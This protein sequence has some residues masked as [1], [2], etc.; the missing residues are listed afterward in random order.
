MIQHGIVI[1]GG[2]LASARAIKS[3]REAGGTGSVFLVTMDED[4][5]YHRPPLSKRYLRGEQEKEEV[6]VEQPDFY[7][8]H[9]VD[10]SL[11]TR[12][13]LLDT[14]A[15]ELELSAGARVGYEQLLIA[16]GAAPRRLG[17]PGEEL[18]NVFTLRRLAD[19][20]RIRQA[21]RGAKR[22]VVV[23]ANF[24][25]MEV[26]ASLTTLGIGVTLVHR[27]SALF[28]V[29]EAPEA[30]RAFVDL[31]REKGVDLASRTRWSSSSGT[32]GSV[33]RERGA[34]VSSTPISRWSA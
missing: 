18:E 33:V 25:G 28:E 20:T 23:G 22:A 16:S 34:A 5:P 26:A 9:E 6:L 4:L 19:S 7:T 11:Q 29:L 30:S 12:V 24:I 14:E 15:K 31:Y 32:E 1:V 21:A 3:Y 8:Q 2:G 17:V 27:G 10:V 13:E